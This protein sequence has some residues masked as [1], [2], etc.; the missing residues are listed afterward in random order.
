MDYK[1]LSEK[2]KTQKLAKGTRTCA[3]CPIPIIVRQ[4]LAQTDVPIAASMA[5]G[6]LEVT[7]SIY[8]DNAWGISSIHNAFENAAATISGVETAHKILNKKGKLNEEQ[9]KFKFVAFGGDGGTFD[10]GLQSLS[11]AVERGHNFLYV[12]YDNGAY[13]NTGNQRSSATPKGVKT[14]TTPAGKEMPRKDMMKIMA[15]H[16][17]PYLAQ[18]AVHNLS[19]LADKAK[20]AFET[21]GPSFLL[22]FSPCVPGWGYSPKD[23]IRISELAFETNFWPLYEIEN[24]KY[25]I[26]AKPIAVKPIQEFLKTQKRFEHLLKNEQAVKEIQES[27][28]KGWQELL[29]SCQD[30]GYDGGGENKETA[31]DEKEVKS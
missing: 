1:E 24:G 17:I 14:E 8:P 2:L 28:D 5:T 25:K 19:D 15:G 18:S 21:K 6:C 16:N 7:T 30:F 23:T 10:I 12:C 9:K 31:E 3:G 22:V 4:I 29:S 20:K 27:V 11:G 26:T 13:Q